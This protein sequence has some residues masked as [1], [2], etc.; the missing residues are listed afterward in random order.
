MNPLW[1]TFSRPLLPFQ[2]MFDCEGGNFMT[3]SW[4]ADKFNAA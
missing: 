2:A 3:A 4:L 1:L